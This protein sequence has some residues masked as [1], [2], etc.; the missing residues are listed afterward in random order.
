MAKIDDNTADAENHSAITA[1]SQK[2][3][4]ARLRTLGLMMRGRG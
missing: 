2:A 1:T 4:M 3:R